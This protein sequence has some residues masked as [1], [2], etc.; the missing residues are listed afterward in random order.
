MLQRAIA[1]VSAVFVLTAGTGPASGA[2]TA[3]EVAQGYRDGVVIAVPRA[4][5]TARSLSQTEAGLGYRTG[6]Q[7][8]RFGGLRI[9]RAGSNESVPEMIARLKATGD[10][11][12]VEPDYVRRAT[13]S[14]DDPRFVNGDQ[15]GLRNDGGDDG[16][17]GADIAAPDGWSVRHD[18]ETVIVAVIDSGIRLD[19]EDLKDNLWSNPG[20][21]A[22]NGIDDDA[23][24]YVDDVHG[25][26][27]IAPDGGDA[28]D[29]SDN[30]GHGTHVAGIIGAVGNN[31]RGIAG[32]AWRVQLMALRF[33]DEAGNGFTSDA[34]M[35]IDY[36]IARGAHIINASYGSDADSYSAA[37]E[38]AIRR[39]RD[40][41]IL[42]V[43]A[44][45]ND[46]RDL[47]SDNEYPAAYPVD[48]LVVV[49]AFSR[50][51][52]MLSFS[53][54]GSGRVDLIAPGAEVLSTGH[55]GSASYVT[56]NGTSMAAPH[57]S[58]ALALLRAAYP[59]DDHR[60]LVNR[61][62]RGTNQDELGGKVRLP[63]GRA[64][65]GWLNLS[66]ALASDDI[67]PVNDDRESP[68]RLDGAHVIARGS[69]RHATV[70]ADEPEHAGRPGHA[71]LWWSWRSSTDRMVSIDTSISADVAAEA[72]DTL[73][74]VYQRDEHGESQ[75]VAS[76][77]NGGR[78]QA[79]ALTFSA[80]AGRDYEIAIDTADGTSALLAFTLDALP[81]NDDF[82][83]AEEISGIGLKLSGDNRAASRETGE[84]RILGQAGGASVWYRWTAPSS[85]PVQVAVIHAAME[86]MVGVYTGTALENL[87][88]VAE[89]DH[90]PTLSG[91][92]LD[93][94]VATFEA[95]TGT[96]YFIA[97]DSKN[98]DGA[99]FSLTINDSIWQLAISGS[100]PA[101][102]SV[103]P[104]GTLYIGGTDHLLHAVTPEGEP[105]WTYATS[106]LIDVGSAAIGPDGTLYVGSNDSYLHAVGPDGKRRWRYNTSGNVV[107]SPAIDSR[108]RPYFRSG[109]GYLYALTTAGGLRWR[110]LI[111]GDSYGSVTIAPDGILYVGGPAEKG[112][113]AYRSDGVLLWNRPT[114][115]DVYTSVSIGPDG[116]LY[117]GTLGGTLYSLNRDGT[118]RWSY[119]TS[120][121]IT[122]S[123]ALEGDTVYFGGYD[124]R[125]HAVDAETGEPRWTADLGGEVRAS[126]PALLDDGSI[127]VGCYDGLV[128]H[129]EPGGK[130][131]RTYATGGIVRS[132]PVAV[133]GRIY[134]GS[135][136][137]RLYAFPNDR[138]PAT[139]GWPM[140]Q[141]SAQRTGRFDLP[142]E[143][144]TVLT[145]PAAASVAPGGTLRL[146]V[147]AA[148]T[149]L[150]Y[151]WSR[152][153]KPIEGSGDAHLELPEFGAGQAGL[154][155]VTISNAAGTLTT[156][157]VVVAPILGKDSLLSGNAALVQ[158][159]ILHPET[160]RHYDQLILTG[161]AASFRADPDQVTR[162]SFIDLSDDIV[163]LE[164]SGD[165]TVTILL[166]AIAGEAAPPVKY[167]QPDVTYLKGHARILVTGATS[168]TYLSI[169]SVGRAN[170]VNQDLFRDGE[171]YDGFA[172][173]ALLAIAAGEEPG[174][175]GF[176]GGNASFF[177]TEGLTGLYAPAVPAGV[178]RVHDISAADEALPVLVTGTV[179]EIGVTGGSLEQPN[180]KAVA[181]GDVTS[182]RMLDGTNS[183]G[184]FLAAQPLRSRL[185]RN[186]EDVTDAVLAG[187]QL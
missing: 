70:E 164:F 79:S 96:T 155:S 15:W 76:N 72:P 66:L 136:D 69:N 6:R 4:A 82:D 63:P 67:R 50:H 116:S 178:V 125:L 24:G 19:H 78:G 36:A 169:F 34:I 101:S 180:G 38:A 46:G 181:I 56:M 28:G 139:G 156:E 94:P 99:P 73:L 149:Q 13:V 91:D 152:N 111:G 80:E 128:Y 75:E 186:G 47:D 147:A 9:L 143:P 131:R 166:E 103:A 98:G 84:P 17:T 81:A 37:E 112:V 174:L 65:A 170:A 41:G 148:G 138:G 140:Y 59:D 83:G 93:D 42:F 26:N 85:G 87:A 86:A 23:N 165:G 31:G 124:M 90:T 25:I 184:V 145:P 55:A 157:P 151:Q 54:Y 141:Y 117:A 182:L 168:D 133:E 29:P 153:G 12:I 171:I 45:G 104:D 97:V 146:E 123:P 115:G 16:L 137:G 106:E 71:S 48:N 113:L 7:F 127:L 68:V 167:V 95:T 132:S 162:L 183:H 100:L 77:D 173:V 5:A 51:G 118:I 144:P 64:M 14:P 39:A 89:S 11:A 129:F 57:V 135:N 43:T 185:E 74:A 122:S 60:A 159:D 134:F 105:K 154:Y 1:A 160:G 27:A 161:P 52:P 21:T 2:V 32:V 62:L 88:V 35:C 179:A 10:Y 158:E 150:N 20:E 114:D 108:G 30:N 176:F 121:S 18:A 40:A 49:G 58:G 142:P 3:K 126:S 109:D 119:A 110:R 22:G 53:N 102:P 61:L 130:L 8:P 33:L 44:A 175:G 107:N 163:Q 172:D 92:R 120:D 187:E 177:A